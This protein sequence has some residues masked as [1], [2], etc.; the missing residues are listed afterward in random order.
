MAHEITDANFA[1][2]IKSS[3]V[4]VV[5]FWAPWCGPCM[6]IAPMIDAI[7]RDFSGKAV[8]AKMNV[9]QSPNTAAQFGIRNIPAILFFKDGKLVDRQSGASSMSALAAKISSYL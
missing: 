4:V 1:Q 7:S 5:D 8:V 6:A 2:T 3:K 9:D